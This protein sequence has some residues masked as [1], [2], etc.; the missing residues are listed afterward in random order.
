MSYFL[1]GTFNAIYNED[2]LQ[3]IKASAKE[4][5]IYIWFNDE[6]E[7]Y[8]E[9]QRMLM[10]QKSKGNTKFV[11][12]S[13]YQPYNSSDVLFPFD[14]FESDVLFADKSRS[15]YKECC[16][17]N[18]DILFEC[19]KNLFN[20]LNASQMEIFVVEGYDDNFSRKIC[21]IDEVKRDLLFQIEN[22][23]SIK[24]CIYFVNNYYA[25]IKNN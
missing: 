2:M 19:F 1:F 13:Q 15:F 7:I 10:E 17:E 5:G 23:L 6:K 12:T 9:I 4:K 20:S 8:N 24:S 3:Q 18:L 16:K 22:E 14:K 11:I 21:N 25:V